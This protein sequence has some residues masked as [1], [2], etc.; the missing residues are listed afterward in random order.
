M[1]QARRDES[2][3]ASWTTGQL[4]T[5]STER[6]EQFEIASAAHHDAVDVALA[7]HSRHVETSLE[8]ACA[9]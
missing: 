1:M 4:D 7:S 9:V 6:L 5:K 2:T 3:S 8:W